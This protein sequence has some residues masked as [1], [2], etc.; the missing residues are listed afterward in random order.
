MLITVLS[1]NWHLNEKCLIFNS[2]L[3]PAHYKYTC[4]LAVTTLKIATWVAKTQ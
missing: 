2:G 3:I 4:I 1:F